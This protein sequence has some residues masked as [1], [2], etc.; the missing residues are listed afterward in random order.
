M[1]VAY[2]LEQSTTVAREGDRLLVKKDGALLQTLFLNKLSQLVVC[3]NI[4]LTPAAVRALLRRE[5]DTTFM[6]LRGNYLGRLQAPYGKNILLRRRQFQCAEDSA[7]SLRTGIAFVKG[8][9][10]N[11]RSVLMRINRNR[12]E[13]DL[14]DPVLQLR[15][16]TEWVESAESLD[17]V[18]GHEGRAAVIYFGALS[19]GINAEGFSF[20]KRT[21]RPP[22]DPFNALLSLGYAFLFNTVNSS[23]SCAG[24]EPFLG[25]LHET[26]YGRPSLALDLMEEWRPLI[27]DTLVLSVINLKVLLPEDFVIDPAGETIDDGLD[28]AD[29]SVS[30]G[31]SDTGS[32]S[33]LPVRLTDDGFR[34]Y[35]VQYERKMSQKIRHPLRGQTLTYRD[36]I[37]EQVYHFSRY[38]RGEASEYIPMAIK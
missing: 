37:M 23:V 13:E 25:Y 22:T 18:R 11:L 36:C 5:I 10:T 21:R 31:N 8:K 26:D 14:A 32:K 19:R 38:L 27:I 1:T 12:P 20:E 34:K 24:F 4:F 28:L 33:K 29:G 16:I 3:G 7:F 15:K 17:V 30:D 35:I 9:I 2:I 6:T